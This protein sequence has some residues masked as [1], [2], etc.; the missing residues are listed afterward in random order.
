M[1]KLA[2]WGRDLAGVCKGLGPVNVKIGEGSLRVG[3]MAKRY[4]RLVAGATAVFGVLCGL[5]AMAS[6]DSEYTQV[7]ELTVQRV[8]K[9]AARLES[10]V[11]VATDHVYQATRWAEDV[12]LH[13][14]YAGPA[15]LRE[16]A[17]QGLARSADGEFNLDVYADRDAKQRLGLMVALKE[18]AQ[19]RPGGRPS[20]LDLALPLLDRFR[21]AQETIP[22]VRWSYFFSASKDMLAMTPWA[23]SRDVLGDEPNAHTFL[24][25]SWTYE[26]TDRGRPE[27]N[28]EHRPYWTKA[29]SDQAGAGLMVSYGMPLYWGEEFVGVIGADV[30][31]NRLAQF[32]DEFPDPEG[33]LVIVDQNGD[34]LAQRHS[35]TAA[36]SDVPT[37]D[38]ILPD[39]LKPWSAQAVGAQESGRQIADW[40]VVAQPISGTQWTMV[41][42]LPRP[43]V[44]AR[45][46][47]LF[48]PQLALTVLLLL[49]L[50]AMNHFLNRWYVAPALS[51]AE[52][53]ASESNA[54]IVEPPRVPEMWQP[55]V[56]AMA[57]AFRERWQYLSDL[58]AAN[59]ALEQRVVERTQALTDANIRLEELATTDPLTGAFNR[60]RL[61]DVIGVECQRV[62][63]GVTTISVLMLDVDHFK[64]INDSYGHSVGDDVL[65][66]VVQRI[67]D[68]IRAT[69][70]VYR[71]GG[72][73]F[74]VLLPMLDNSGAIIS[75][76]RL[77]KIVEDTPV[78][79]DGHS[80]AL[81]ISVGIASYRHGESPDQ[82]LAR[83]DELLYAA[84][85]AGRNRVMA[86]D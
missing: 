43:I 51:I 85:K 15:D 23:A 73:E 77:R 36:A 86:G 80:I 75:A 11:K 31:L 6:W 28:P 62:L 21:Y 25:H 7:I 78:E 20:N 29:Y 46:V 76:E 32:L 33:I 66:A 37:I 42:L 54:K 59:E 69:D 47:A 24:Q 55:W 82:L 22:I 74:L 2:L 1:R 65:C 12:P 16:A 14:P 8:H 18:A 19:A 68:S 61:L 26:I 40:H 72:E 27:N 56:S 39:A 5:T 58:R 67:K 44:I 57:R 81:T 70:S 34:L 4:Q 38:S 84:K 60:R 30:L 41:F 17:L 13:A 48:A 9:D 52:F 64:K 49:T 45:V 63:R 35:A 79:V 53:V 71:Y 10:I 3:A 50:A 83:A